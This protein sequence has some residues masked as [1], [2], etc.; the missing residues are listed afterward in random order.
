[1]NKIGFIG[2]GNMGRAMARGIIDVFGK[3]QV[4]FTEANED[5]AK[6]FAAD[7]KVQYIVGLSELA[8]AV[9]YIILAIKPQVYSEVLGQLK[10]YLTPN[11][12]I[13]SIA[14]GISIQDVKD[15][16]ALDMRVVRAMPNTP[17]LVGEGMSAICFSE[18][19][20]NQ[21]EKDMVGN[22]F[23]AFGKHVVLE[24]KLMNAVVGVS[25]SSP[26]YVYI[27][28]EALADAGVKY[29]IPRDL[30]YHLAAQTVLGSA[31]MVMDTNIHPGQ[32]KDQVCS[33]G[34]TTIAAVAT[35]EETGF[36]NAIIKAVDSCYDKCV[37]MA[38]K[39]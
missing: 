22:I 16:L 5:A 38:S 11:H 15:Q 28:I 9:K 10:Q 18:D 1:M 20:F 27:F 14:P 30:A 29:G 12:V 3:N 23:N 32:L 19:T 8:N 33:P 31:K 21:E 34:G 36:R 26:A 2:M 6:Q 39:K 37:D 7:H 24:E 4:V 17:A 35:L 25:G 13:I